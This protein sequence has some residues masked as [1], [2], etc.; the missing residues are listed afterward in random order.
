MT[1]SQTIA[2]TGAGPDLTPAE[3]AALTLTGAATVAFGAYGAATGASSTTSYVV[4]VAALAAGLV[5]LRRRP[6][7]AVLALALAG[8]AVAHLAGGLVQV[9]DGVLYNASYRT[10]VLQYDHLVHS[11]AILVGTL[12]VWTLF[13]GRMAGTGGRADVLVW[14][15]AG[16]GLGALNELVEFLATLAHGGDGV[17]G[18]E[19]TGWDLVS[20]LL[21]AAAAG[22]VLARRPARR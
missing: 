1:A 5:A 20:N 17:G 2:R 16:L 21:G 3:R 10:E 11:T 18:Y 9:G 14:V 13:A 8:L 22:V 15:L 4:V 19:N 12:T 7:P 6:L